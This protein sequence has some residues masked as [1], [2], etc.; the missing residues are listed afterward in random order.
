MYGASTSCSLDL[1]EAYVSVVPSTC[2][3]ALKIALP[4]GRS[5]LIILDVFSTG[6]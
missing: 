4:L 5:N 3:Y 2:G 1:V 6:Y